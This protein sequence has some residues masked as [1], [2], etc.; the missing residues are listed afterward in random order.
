MMVDL[1]QTEA[2]NL[3]AVFYPDQE[4]VPKTEAMFIL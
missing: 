1:S 3:E 4:Q 2:H